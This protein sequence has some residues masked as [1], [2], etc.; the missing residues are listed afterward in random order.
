LK[1]SLLIVAIFISNYIFPNRIDELKT[2]LDIE[3]F[4]IKIDA[5]FA[6]GTNFHIPKIDT[7][8]IDKNCSQIINLWSILNFEKVDLTNDGLTDLI[9]L[10]HLNNE[11]YQ[12]LVIDHGNN[13]FEL[14]R[15]LD[16]LLSE[17]ELIKPIRIKNSNALRIYRSN[18]YDGINII[19][20]LIYKFNGFIELNSKNNILPIDEIELKYDSYCWGEDCPTFNLKIDKNGKVKLW[21]N[22]THYF[23]DKV[24]TKQL[25]DS[26]FRNMMSICEYI[27][28]NLKNNYAIN[29]SHQP[30]FTLKI[31]FSNGKTKEIKDYGM[32]GTLGLSY[33][34]TQILNLGAEINQD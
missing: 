3:N 31:S 5:E 32:K 23:V 25:S 26:G 33:L 30:T 2:T 27:A 1:K 13:D 14:L 22:S 15:I 19:D 29:W 20:T 34:Y 18:N 17:C 9:F 7:I 21:N 6:S 12:Y 8:I 4:I 16:G 10:I 11:F 24:C 28:F